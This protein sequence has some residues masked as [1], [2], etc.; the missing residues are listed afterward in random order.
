MKSINKSIIHGFPCI[1]LTRL[2]L[3]VEM[4]RGEKKKKKKKKRKRKKCK[5]GEGWPEGLEFIKLKRKCKC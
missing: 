4:P 2:V 3:C 5:N 1:G